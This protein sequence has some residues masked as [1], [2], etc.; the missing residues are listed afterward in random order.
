MKK[1]FM[2]TMAVAVAILILGV[3]AMALSD[4]GAEP[5][6]A[7]LDKTV[8][9]QLGGKDAIMQDQAGRPLYPIVYNG[10]YYLPA[11]AV[12][13]GLNAYVQWDGATR[14]LS[15]GG[16]V[17]SAALGLATNV[18]TFEEQ[19]DAVKLQSTAKDGKVVTHD[20]GPLMDVIVNDFN[21]LPQITVSNHAFSYDGIEVM[22]GN[23][24]Y[25]Q[26]IL[27][28][29]REQDHTYEVSFANA[30]GEVLQAVTMA[31]MDAKVVDI[32]VGGQG[33]LHITSTVVPAE[34]E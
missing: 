34:A 28:M 31:P 23:R 21:G 33:A 32:P 13:E 24:Q 2:A 26:R 30:G 22:L 12:G 15:V 11:R 25:T 29:N 10:N 17:D 7:Y 18:M 6:Q 19:T 8:H 16:D 20:S 4:V 9:V 3:S 1:K 27:V 5:I 14:T